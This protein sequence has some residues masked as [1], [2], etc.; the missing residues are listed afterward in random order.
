MDTILL[1]VLVVLVLGLLTKAM[2][3]TRDLDL[4]IRNTD[5]DDPAP[6]T[7]SKQTPVADPNLAI[8]LDLVRESIAALERT[9]VRVAGQ[10]ENDPQHPQREADQP[11]EAITLADIPWDPTD[12]AP[13][14]V[15]AEYAPFAPQ[16]GNDAPAPVLHPLGIPGL[17]NPFQ[18]TSNITA[19]L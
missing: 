3:D 8:A 13:G 9:V 19:D 10:P 11:A 2:I 6:F 12:N 17:A 1:V 4:D 5:P 14:L 16:W 7:Y 18:P 15:D